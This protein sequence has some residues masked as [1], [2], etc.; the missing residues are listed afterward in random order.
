VYFAY[1][2]LF[3]G[4]RLLTSLLRLDP[5]WLFGLQEAQVLGTLYAVAGAA[6]LVLLQ[7]RSRLAR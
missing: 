6:G 1:L 2:F 5:V 4:F 3:G 7:R